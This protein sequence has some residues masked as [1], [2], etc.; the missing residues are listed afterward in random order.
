MLCS[1]V[2]YTTQGCIS[3]SFNSHP[4]LLRFFNKNKPRVPKLK[5]AV[6]TIFA[7]TWLLRFYLKNIKNKSLQNIDFT[8][9]TF[10]PFHRMHV[11]SPA[12]DHGFACNTLKW[13]QIAVKSETFLLDLS[14]CHFYLNFNNNLFR[15]PWKILS[16]DN[17]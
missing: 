15:A 16:S 9:P 6:S 4:D 5:W 7:H 12:T 2:N 11:C 13:Q 14:F 8:T 3:G 10:S 1:I 17:Y